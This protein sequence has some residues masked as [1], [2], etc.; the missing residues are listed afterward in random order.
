METNAILAILSVSNYHI[1]TYRN[2]KV[3]LSPYIPKD[4]RG[5]PTGE[6]AIAPPFP[7]MVKVST[8]AIVTGASLREL[9]GD[10]RELSFIGPRG[11]TTWATVEPGMKIA[12][13]NRDGSRY[14]LCAI[15]NGAGFF[16]SSV[17][18]APDGREYSKAEI[19]RF[20]PPRVDAD[21]IS[22]PFSG[23]VSLE[24][25]GEL[26][27]PP[28]ETPAP[29]ETGVQYVALSNGATISG[30]EVTYTYTS[31]SNV[32]TAPAAPVERPTTTLLPDVTREELERAREKI[33]RE[34]K[35][36]LKERVEAERQ[37]V[38]TAIDTPFPSL[39]ESA[40]VNRAAWDAAH[41]GE[42]SPF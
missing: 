7:R 40:R 3:E 11:K 29:A 5:N 23:I 21:Y 1:V 24:P 13:K 37:R 12:R 38:V 6:P 36:S 27:T 34:A 33:T 28:E 16:G 31:T 30:F 22:L 35:M 19:G 17:F 10:V 41:V 15:D 39:R 25:R 20:L 8:F 2:T 42:P 4:A 9:V 18:T 14:L 26:T 32:T